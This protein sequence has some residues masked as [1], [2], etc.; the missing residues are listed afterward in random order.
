M[1]SFL[2]YSRETK[3]NDDIYDD[4]RHDLLVKQQSLMLPRGG[5]EFVVKLSAVETFNL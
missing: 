1:R 4:E 5:R 2:L 3:A